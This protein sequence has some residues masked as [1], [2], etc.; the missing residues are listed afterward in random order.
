MARLGV[1]RAA[2]ALGTIAVLP[3][4]MLAVAPAAQA[5]S[6]TYEG[7][8]VSQTSL[9]V[10]SA[11]TSKATKVGSLKRGTTVKIHCKVFGPSVGGNDLWYKLGNGRWVT[12]RYVANVG[13]APRFCGDRNTSYTGK[14]V[15]QSALN[16]R[17]GP[18]TANAKVSSA[19]RGISLDI[20]CKVDSQPI[21]GNPRWYQLVGDGGGQWVAA[22]YVSNVG[23]APPNC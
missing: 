3:M 4:A 22:R 10:R 5:A 8:V 16:V 14:V 18:N 15:S 7:K 11:P 2:V 12:A 9:N 23:A 1:R 21:N 6:P 13:A 20:V 17:S 19:P